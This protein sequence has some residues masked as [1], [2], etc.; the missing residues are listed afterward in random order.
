MAVAPILGGATGPAAPAKDPTHQRQKEGKS[1]LGLK[2]NCS[3]AFCQDTD[4]VQATRQTY[5]EVHCPTFD[6]EGS[7]LSSLF[8]EM[9]T[10]ANLLGSK[11]YEVQVVWAG[12]KDLRFAHHVIRD[13]PKGLQFFHLVSPLELPKVM[14]LEGIHHPD[15]LHHHAGLLY[16]PWCRKEG[17]NEGTVVNHLQTMCYRLGLVCSRCLCHSTTSSK[18]MWHH[19]QVC[20]QSDTKEEDGGP[21]DDDTSTS[22]WL[23]PSCPLHIWW[24]LRVWP[25]HCLLWCTSSPQFICGFPPYQICL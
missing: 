7:H 24:F 6:Q 3:E 10:S 1:F 14:G 5:F 16:C 2:E 22:D 8:W 25:K 13:L 23:T 4:L 21:S 19:G 11:I 12:M 17:Q 18:A 9:I 20:R 15:T